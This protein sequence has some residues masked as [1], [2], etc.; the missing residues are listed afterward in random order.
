MHN[1][2]QNHLQE[3]H[4]SLDAEP[5]TT[6]ERFH[7][8]NEI[9]RD[10]GHK[11]PQGFYLVEVKEDGERKS[12][13]GKGDEK[14]VVHD[15]ENFITVKVGPTP[16]SDVPPN[17][18]EVFTAGL[19]ALGYAVKIL[20]AN[21][22]SMQFPYVVEVGKHT[23]KTVTLGFFVPKTFPVDPPSGPHVNPQIHGG[24]AQGQE[25]PTSNIHASPFGGDFE[26][27]SRPYPSWQAETSK[28]VATYMAYI[29]QLWA[30]Q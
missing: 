6:A 20:D 18:V 3:I 4:F 27:W 19:T 15:G 8:P 24:K 29:R 30:T 22:G 26:Y 5:F 21:A 28:T 1:D 13:Q 25:H 17:G 16:V 2:N 14:I 11:D 12:F 7:T 10:F 23:G 9:L